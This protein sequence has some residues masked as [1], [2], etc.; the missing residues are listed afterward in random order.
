MTGFQKTIAKDWPALC[1]LAI[2][3][4]LIA[5]YWNQIP[6]E[7]PM[8]WKAGG[9]VSRWGEKGFEVFILPLFAVAVYLL[10]IAVPY[11]DPKRKARSEQK[12][13]R[14]VRFILPLVFTGLFLVIF[15][16]WL[17]LNFEINKA[18]GLILAFFFMIL[19]NYM[20]S[21]KPN[22]FIGIKTPW[23]LENE[24]IWRRTHRMGGRLWVI[25]GILLLASWFFIPASYFLWAL[26]GTSLVLGLIPTVYSFYLYLQSNKTKTGQ[27]G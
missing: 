18:I 15:A 25:G 16:Q 5:A 6:N 7:I 21:L 8:Q 14:A 3:F 19:G 10:M 26:T 12:S 27:P 4:I 13:L 1:M 24:E 9:Q 2:P 23:T 20:Q 17:G 22:Y 11:I